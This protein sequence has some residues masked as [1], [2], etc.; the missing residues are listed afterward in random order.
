MQQ[1]IL[2]VALAI[3]FQIT[4]VLGIFFILGYILSKLQEWTQRNY[5]RSIGWKGIL[6]TAWI[7]TPIH[8]VG[9]WIFAT[10]FRHRTTKIS[11]FQPNKKTGE[12]GLVEHTFNPN[13]LYQKI[14]NFFIGAAPMIFGSIILWVLVNYLLPDG[15]EVFAQ[16]IESKNTLPDLFV[17][18]VNS[19][20][21]LLTFD[22]LGS[23]H[24]WL[25]L[26]LSFCV[27]SHL[28]PSK[29]DR[30]GMWHGFGWI[31][32]ILIILNLFSTLF[33]L[34]ITKHILKTS[35][36][37]SIFTTLFI[38]AIMISTIHLMISTIILRPFR[39]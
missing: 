36:Y 10:I 28:A 30:K 19:L 32:A 1:F 25:F 33:Q 3:I 9:H 12:L 39:R 7:G 29:A 23:W 20:K 8:E 35:H 22:N 4:G 5:F 38:Y 17:A 15:K 34:D 26:Y 21:V 18:I 6:W 2:S 13:S 24:F 31:V 16:L 27:A 11:I 14:G 37:L